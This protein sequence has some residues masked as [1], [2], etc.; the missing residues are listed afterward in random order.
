[1]R[2]SDKIRDFILDN[3]EDNPKSISSMTMKHFGLSRQAVSHNIRN[4]IK[5]GLLAAKGNT[6][7]REYTLKPITDKVFSLEISKDLQEHNVW[8]Q[9]FEDYFKQFNKNIVGICNYGFTEMFNNIVDHSDGLESIIGYTHLP[10]KVMIFV[11]DNGIGIFN[12]I[13]M[14]L[15]LSDKREAILELS[16]GKL[17]TDPDNHTGEGIFYTSRIF[18]RFSILSGD[19]F[20]SH[21]HLG[22]WLIE[23]K[24]EETKGTHVRMVIS[25]KSPRTLE[26]LFN[27]F[28][29]EQYDYTFNGTHVPLLLTKYGDEKLVS[30][31]QAKR[32]LARFE[33][34]TEVILDFTG[35]DFVGQAF[36]DEIFRVYKLKNP[37]TKILWVKA[38]ER[39][40]T[41]IKGIISKS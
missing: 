30:R 38:N 20:F 19:L 4:L 25:T 41:M 15:R 23:D 12:K 10:N 6:R 33:R 14:E 22:D 5:E 28:A 34:F 37:K 9:Y 21:S 29:G 7:N 24:E 31:S 26:E 18:D 16:K 2:N 39:I 32:V 8:T 27:E 1:M 3:V 36:V 13:A 40:D 35:V 17:T 11:S